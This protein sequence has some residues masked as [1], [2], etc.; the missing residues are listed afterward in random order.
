M[1]SKTNEDKID[2]LTRLV[3]GHVEQLLAVDA[4]LDV[5]VA[6]KSELARE[7][8]AFGKLPAVFE[9]QLKDLRGWRESFGTIDQ[10]KVD[11]ALMRKETEELKKWQDEVKS[12]KDEWGKRIWAL[13]GQILAVAVGWALG[14]FSR[15]R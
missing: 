7:V 1:P 9:Q 4:R 13:A 6:E 15:P 5:I 2:D 8:V 3:S 14:Y 12:Q 11:Q 10:L